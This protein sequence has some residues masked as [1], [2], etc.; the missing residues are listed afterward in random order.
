MYAYCQSQVGTNLLGAYPMVSA[1]NN[2]KNQGGKMDK[3]EAGCPV[4][5]TLSQLS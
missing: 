1:L 4:E 2:T 5:I 3:T